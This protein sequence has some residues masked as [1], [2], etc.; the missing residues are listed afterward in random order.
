[1]MGLI[2]TLVALVALSA[3][4]YCGATVD[5][6]DHTFFEHVG[7]IWR[8]DETQQLVRGVQEESGPVVDR[9]K[10]GIEAGLDE[11]READAGPQRAELVRGN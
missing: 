8:T 1:M 10:R 9:V 6:G 5:L 11:A 2:R 3:M 7:R 4:A